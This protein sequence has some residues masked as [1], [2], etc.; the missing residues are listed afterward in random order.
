MFLAW[1]YCHR[2]W[3]TEKTSIGHAVFTHLSQLSQRIGKVFLARW[4]DDP[5]SGGMSPCLPACNF[6]YFAQRTSGKRKRQQI[7]LIISEWAI[8]K[9][10][11]WFFVTDLS[12]VV[13][14]VELRAS[15]FR[16]GVQGQSQPKS[17]LWSDPM[18]QRPLRRVAWLGRKLT[19]IYTTPGKDREIRREQAHMSWGG[20]PELGPLLS[21]SVRIVKLARRKANFIRRTAICTRSTQ[22]W[23]PSRSTA[24][25][26]NEEKWEW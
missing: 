12:G 21:S 26:Q 16:G 13:V 6:I 2:V 4:W 23:S 17:A 11:N 15:P 10:I 14:V 25:G 20:G 5:E 24:G 22:G 19:P 18:S 7:K 8:D 9:I 1:C 3:T